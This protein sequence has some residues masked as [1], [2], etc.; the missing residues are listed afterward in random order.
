M[1]NTQT[2]NAPGKN[3]L[4]VTGILLVVFGSL[5]VL[6]SIIIL[7]LSIIHAD[8]LSLMAHICFFSLIGALYIFS[9]IAGI[10]HCDNA[11]S[12]NI[13]FRLGV[14]LLAALILIPIILIIA[15]VVIEVLTDSTDSKV[16]VYLNDIGSIFIPSLPFALPLSILYL[17]GAIKNKKA[18]LA[19]ISTATE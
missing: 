16:G 9:G 4:K 17:I 5:I 14:F 10:R 8:F 6:P 15:S 3:F 13:C 11:Q 1:G 12:A 2:V 18:A 7:V 19:A